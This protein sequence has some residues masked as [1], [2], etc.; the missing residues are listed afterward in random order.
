MLGRYYARHSRVNASHS[1]QQ[2]SQSVTYAR[3]YTGPPP[4]HGSQS[5]LCLLVWLVCACRLGVLT[6][7]ERLNRDFWVNVLLTLLG[8]LPGTRGHAYAR[9]PAQSLT[10]ALSPVAFPHI[11]TKVSNTWLCLW[12]KHCASPFA[13]ACVNVL[14]CPG[15]W[16]TAAS[17][18]VACA[19]SSSPQV[20]FTLS[21]SS[22][23][24]RQDPVAS[25][26]RFGELI[27]CPGA[28]V[29]QRSPH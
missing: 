9:Q 2:D 10:R 6:E 21:G 8:W 29:Q 27:S 15:A 19:S 20:S 18:L 26:L 24:G 16:G 22:C 25:T 17:D 7:T 13:G 28:S 23:T 1:V 11:P 14:P 12:R 3:S 5:S 4:A